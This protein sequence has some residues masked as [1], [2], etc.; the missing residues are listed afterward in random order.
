MGDPDKLLSDL[1]DRQR[2]AVTTVASPLA[3]LAGA[4]S[5]KTRVL[6]RR[7]AWLAAE[8]VID[9]RHALAVTFTRKAAGE[10]SDRLE[11]LGVRR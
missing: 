6:T 11:G 1:N 3:I 8:G 10:L 5:G 7:I 2:E 9:A 4:G